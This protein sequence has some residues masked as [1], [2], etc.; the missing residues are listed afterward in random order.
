MAMAM[1]G[2]LAGRPAVA[3][4]PAAVAK[5]PAADR[6]LSC[7]RVGKGDLKCSSRNAYVTVSL[8]NKSGHPVIGKFNIMYSRCGEPGQRVKQGDV[9][10][11]SREQ[12]AIDTPVRTI[13]VALEPFCADVYVSSCNGGTIECATAFDSAV[14]MR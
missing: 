4:E 11:Q 5:E 14:Y 1:M 7:E 10:A 6:A 2:C 13:D 12:V 8:T 3:E 9:K